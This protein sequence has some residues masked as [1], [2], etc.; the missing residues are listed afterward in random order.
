MQVQRLSP[1]AN[2]EVILRN[3]RNLESASLV[4]SKPSDE[5]EDIH[6]FEA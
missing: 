3:A 4:K 6:R 2:L 5:A 1:T